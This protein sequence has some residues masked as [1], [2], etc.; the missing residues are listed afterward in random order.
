MFVGSWC[1]QCLLVFDVVCCCVGVG[2][3][4]LYCLLFLLVLFGFVSSSHFVVFSRSH[5]APACGNPP[6]PLK[7]QTGEVIILFH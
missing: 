2:F 7:G 6:V 1:V 4:Y 5:S 3:C